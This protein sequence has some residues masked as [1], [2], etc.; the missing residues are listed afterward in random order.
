[1][2]D[3]QI[4]FVDYSGAEISTNWTTGERYR[5]AGCRVHRDSTGNGVYLAGT[6]QTEITHVE[7]GQD[8]IQLLIV[9]DTHIGR[10]VHPGTGAKIDPLAALAKAVEYGIEQQVDGV[11]HVGDIFHESVTAGQ[12][13]F[14]LIDVLEPLAE[15]EI[16]FYYI[17][18]NHIG[19]LGQLLLEGDDSRSA[20]HLDTSGV[21]VGSTVRLYGIDHIPGETFQNKVIR[22]GTPDPGEVSILVLHQ[23]LKQLSGASAKSVDLRDLQAAFGRPFDAVVC[24]HHHDATYE[25]WLGKPVLYTGAS[26]HMS[27]NENASDRLAWLLTV[28]S[29]SVSVKR[30]PIP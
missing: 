29:G 1:M 30:Y 23:T 2:D 17:Q 8:P 22:F 20:V 15:A 10:T 25:M 13:G 24:G 16:P 21:S 19:E 14:T 9:G 27:T 18:G 5:I 6:K 26:E 11:V 12:A 28:K 4:Q 7:S 3:T